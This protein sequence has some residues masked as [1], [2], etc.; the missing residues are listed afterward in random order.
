MLGRFFVLVL[1]FWFGWTCH[2]VYIGY[3]I[4][5]ARIKQEAENE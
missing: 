1:T 4:E 5:R 2:Y 3:K